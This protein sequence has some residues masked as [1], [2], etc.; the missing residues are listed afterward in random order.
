LSRFRAIYRVCKLAGVK[1]HPHQFRDTFA[2]ELLKRG[3]DIRTVQLLLGHDSVRTTEKHYAPW[4]DAFQVRLDAA[5]AKLEFGE[6]LVQNLV[7]KD[8][9]TGKLLKI[10]G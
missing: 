6:S 7:Q 8:G 1:G 4:V 10:K 5:T 9:A 3:E 2:V